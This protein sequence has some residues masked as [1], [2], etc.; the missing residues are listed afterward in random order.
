MSRGLTPNPD[1]QCN[2]EIKFQA[3][4]AHARSLGAECVATGH[5]ARVRHDE[6]GEGRI[7]VTLDLLLVSSQCVKIV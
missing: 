5:Y 3:L 2:R 6:D 1:L 7:Y 4:L